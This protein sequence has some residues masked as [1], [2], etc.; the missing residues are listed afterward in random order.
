MHHLAGQADLFHQDNFVWCGIGGGF[1]R[2]IFSYPQEFMATCANKTNKEILVEQCQLHFIDKTALISKNLD[3]TR[4]LR[5]P[6]DIQES[7]RSKE[8]ISEE[9]YISSL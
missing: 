7:S 4:I 2:K 5:V 8:R 9:E 1:K 6:E 3:D